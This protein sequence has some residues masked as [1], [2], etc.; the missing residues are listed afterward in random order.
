MAIEQEIVSVQWQWEET[1]SQM[2][3]DKQEKTRWQVTLPKREVV[4]TKQRRV[5]VSISQET[6]VVL[7]KFE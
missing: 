7:V 6:V 1:L 5:R 4:V 2:Q 3:S